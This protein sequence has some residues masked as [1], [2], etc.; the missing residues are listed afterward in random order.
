MEKMYVYRCSLSFSK[1]SATLLKETYIETISFLRAFPA[2][3]YEFEKDSERLIYRF[4][5]YHKIY[6]DRMR[7]H[8]EKS[9]LHFAIYHGMWFSE[10]EADF[11][12]APDLNIVK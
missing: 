1:V 2:T 7:R 5:I 6:S 8:F 3:R 12:I 10:E 11:E 4:D 9:I